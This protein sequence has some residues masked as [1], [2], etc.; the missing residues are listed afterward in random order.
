ML[1]ARLDKDVTEVN[2]A[3]MDLPTTRTGTL[4]RSITR[5]PQSLSRGCRAL[6]EH[7]MTDRAGVL[8]LYHSEENFRKTVTGL[9]PGRSHPLHLDW[10]REETRRKA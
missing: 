5:M 6:A 9:L 3:G 7:R 4:A 8:G 10:L 1:L 2:E